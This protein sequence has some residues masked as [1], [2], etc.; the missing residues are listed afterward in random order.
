MQQSLDDPDAGR[1]GASKTVAP[2]PRA[3]RD[4]FA[5]DLIHRKHEVA[6]DVVQISNE[7]F[8]WVPPL[9]NRIDMLA[10]R[11]QE[12]VGVKVAGTKPLEI[13]RIASD[14]EPAV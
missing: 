9:R 7:T 1:T 4:Q 3:R 6:R 13:D 12:P 14:I 5:P 2:R 10:H 11:H 8:F